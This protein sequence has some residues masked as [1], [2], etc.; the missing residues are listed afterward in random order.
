MGKL[1]LNIPT[2]EAFISVD[3][4]LGSS[5]DSA[6]EHYHGYV[7]FLTGFF[8]S[9]IEYCH[10]IKILSDEEG[11]GS[12]AGFAAMERLF[13]FLADIK[14]FVGPNIEGE[15]MNYFASVAK[16]DLYMCSKEYVTNG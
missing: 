11:G 16:E 4:F 7:K 12:E 13:S 2:H 15:I 5:S 14:I 1:L 9:W 10:K 8:V 6:S 3:R